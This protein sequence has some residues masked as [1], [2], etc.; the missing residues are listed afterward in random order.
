MYFNG[1]TNYFEELPKPGDPKLEE[2]YKKQHEK[3]KA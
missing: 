1:A 2:I 3:L